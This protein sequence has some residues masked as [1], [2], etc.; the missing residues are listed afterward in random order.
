MSVFSKNLR[1]LRE[2]MGLKLSDFEQHGIKSG[3][4]SNYELGKTEPKLETIMFFSKFFSM[5]VDNFLYSDMERYYKELDDPNGIFSKQNVSPLSTGNLSEQKQN[6]SEQNVRPIPE[7]ER[8]V[9]RIDH[10]AFAET[11]SGGIPLIPIDAAAGF[12]SGVGAQIMEYECEQ[13]Q[14]PGF[15]GAEF[16][17]RISGD[18]MTPKYE[19]GDI[20]A[21]QRLEN[22]T[23]LQWNKVYVVDSEQGVLVKRIKPGRADDTL[24][25]V[26]DNAEYAPFEIERRQVYGL[27]R[28][29]GLIRIE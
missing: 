8:G 10:E 26:S 17:I 16:L 19:S 18:S 27:G 29:V 7:I 5:S 4:M 20:V 9:K 21:C 13:Y 6:L 24:T 1:V 28:V 12:L 15:K 25:L 23:F 11:P 2:R 14:I 3:T 22:D